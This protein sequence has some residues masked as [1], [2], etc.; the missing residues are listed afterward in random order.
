MD[1]V[2]VGII[3]IGNMG[4]GHFKSIMGGKVPGM[5]LTADG[6]ET[7]IVIAPDRV[8]NMGAQR[9]AWFSGSK[10]LSAIS[11]PSLVKTIT[12]SVP[13]GSATAYEFCYI[14]K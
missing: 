12:L 7:A 3:G 8:D 14:G 11:D 9:V 6:L 4:S 5:T 2:R 1:T 10:L 13:D